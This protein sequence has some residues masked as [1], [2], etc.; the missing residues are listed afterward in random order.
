MLPQMGWLPHH[1]AYKRRFLG[2]ALPAW[3]YL[4]ADRQT[5]QIALN[6]LGVKGR[7][8]SE[9]GLSDEQIEERIVRWVKI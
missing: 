5:H 9:C 1:C 7:C 2:Q 8:V 4:L 3:H 6:R